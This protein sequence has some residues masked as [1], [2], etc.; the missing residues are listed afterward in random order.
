MAFNE[1][2][3]NEALIHHLTAFGN[4]DLDEI[5]K[6]YTDESEVLT[7]ADKLTGLVDIRQFFRPDSHRISIRDEQENRYR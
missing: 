6:D 4:N 7:P 1:T 2:I 5:L 3:T